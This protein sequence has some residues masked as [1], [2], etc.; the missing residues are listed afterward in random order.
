MNV[1]TERKLAARAKILGE[2]AD[3]AAF[4]ELAELTQSESPLVRRIAASA[5]G[6]LAGVADSASGRSSWLVLGWGVE[7]QAQTKIQIMK[8]LIR[9]S[10]VCLTFPR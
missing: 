8:T 4:G 7:A 1:G 2:S 5:L 3:A 10:I 6:K 9:I